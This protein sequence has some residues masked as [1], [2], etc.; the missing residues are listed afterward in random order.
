LAFA[1]TLGNLDRSRV[2]S[3]EELMRAGDVTH[4]VKKIEPVLLPV[5]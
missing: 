4:A 2:I 5:R 1:L 3:S